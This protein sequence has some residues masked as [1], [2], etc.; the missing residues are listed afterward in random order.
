MSIITDRAGEK[1]L[2]LAP[3]SDGCDTKTYRKYVMGWLAGKTV[4]LE[5]LTDFCVYYRCG[6]DELVDKIVRDQFGKG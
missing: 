3:P 4:S 1:L 2:E 5:D 6:C